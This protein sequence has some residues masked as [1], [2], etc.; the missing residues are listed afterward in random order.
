PS[1]YPTLPDGTPLDSDGDGLLD[2]WEDG[3]LWADGNPGIN[4]SGIWPGTLPAATTFR[5]VMLCVTN[6]VTNNDGL[7]VGATCASKLHKDLFV[8]ID[9]MGAPDGTFSHNPDVSAPQA[10]PNVVFA[11]ANVPTPL[12]SN[13]DGQP[14]IRLHVQ[15]SDL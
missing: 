3:S 15:R 13:P 5:D 14:G 9:Y 1:T 7:P 8:E 10:I 11:F 2:C 12:V 6:P 4:F